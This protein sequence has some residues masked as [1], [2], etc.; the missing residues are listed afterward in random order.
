[1]I[2]NGSVCSVLIIRQ[3]VHKSKAKI[4]SS[5]QK[6]TMKLLSIPL[7]L[8]QRKTVKSHY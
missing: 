7:G 3:D 4:V 1:M 8:I 2:A 5:M 6:D